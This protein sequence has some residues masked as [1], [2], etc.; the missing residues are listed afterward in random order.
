[1]D[2]LLQE[3]KTGKRNLFF[4]QSSIIL[5]AITTVAGLGF[6]FLPST[7][8]EIDSTYFYHRNFLCGVDFH[9]ADSLLFHLLITKRTSKGRSP[10]DQGNCLCRVCVRIF[11]LEVFCWLSLELYLWNC[12]FLERNGENIFTTR[13]SP[14]Y[15]VADV[16]YGKCGTRELLIRNMSS[17]Q[18][19][20]WW[21]AITRVSD[22]LSTVMLEPK[23]VLLTK[24][25]GLKTA[26]FG[27]VV[28]MADYYPAVHR[29]R[30]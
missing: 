4:L 30:W 18:I 21:F 26:V 25:M 11:S 16:H 2:G 12:G 24:W 20:L 23:I 3:Y 14:V 15:M 10:D 13:F 1:M 17:F 8:L 19:P 28:R 9:G 22:I 6:W 29:E 5:S 27:A 7:R